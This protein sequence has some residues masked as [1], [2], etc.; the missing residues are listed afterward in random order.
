MANLKACVRRPRK[1][2]F[3]QVYIRVT[4]KRNAGF[5]K[6]DKM[7]TKKELTKTNEIKDPFVLNYCSDVIIR[8]NAL[9][10]TVNIDQW[11][12]NQVIE[13]LTTEAGDVC[14]SDYAKIHIN[15][16]IN[17]GHERNAKNY[18]L[19]VAH[20]ER[21]VGSN[22]IMFGQLT[23]AVLKNWIDSLRQT[24]RAK[25][26]YPVCVRQIFRA[27]IQELND[28]EKGIIKIKFNPWNKVKIPKA[29]KGTQRAISAE[30][31]RE[32]FNRPL[33]ETKM[34]SSLPE[35]G[36]DVAML[37]L[38]LGGINTVDLFYMKKTDYRDGA[39]CY[40]RAKTRNSRADGAYIEMRVEPFI[41]PI[42]D[43][44]LAAEDDE[45]LFKFHLRYCDS[46]S[47]SA[48][49]NNGIRKI[50][51]DMGMNKEDMYCVYTFR[52]TWGTIAQ[53]DCDANL[54]EVA[55]GMNHSSGFNI[56]RGYVKIDFSPAWRL[57]AKVIEFIFFS[58]KKSK[59]GI[60][61]D[62]EEPKDKL[63]RLS[64]KKLV[65]GRAYFKGEVLAEV[66][67]SGF[68]TIDEV[69]RALIPQLPNTI[70]E[71]AA[72]QFRITNVDTGK[73]AVYERTKGKGF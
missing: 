53:N 23:S 36:R 45:Y 71:R 51:A 57:N 67:D 14:F 13:F 55:F 65:N 52:H 33:P 6:T 27:A 11:D 44:Y 8:Y 30:A 24:N 54:F 10:N 3:W 20:L 37:V 32:F 9:L 50:C 46:D 5:I 41:Q 38:C 28:E 15:R 63:F 48:N 26:M 62:I 69:L 58:N 40:Q 4:H 17:G 59:Q 19:A 18:K 64:A 39:I 56:T 25:E 47:F 35:L 66:Q 34:L 29:D 2:G 49:V 60:A 22:C 72:V 61:K 42:F 21:Y 43:K 16:M 31:C 1:D 68:N 7:V 70:P 12:V 73:E